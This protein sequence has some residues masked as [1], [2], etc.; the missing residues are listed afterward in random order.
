MN[1]IK[2]A[3]KTADLCYIALG[4]VLITICSWITVP[5]AVPF[6]MQTFAVF[7]VLIILG[8]K[9]GILSIIVY[10]AMGLIGIP[11]FS[12][13]KAGVGVIFGLTGGYIVGFIFI[14]LIYW[15]AVSLF[16]EKI[17]VELLS[18]LIGLIVCYAFGTAW[19]MIAYARA[20]ESVGILS[21]ISMCVFPF[22]IPDLI[23]LALSLIIGRKLRTL[24]KF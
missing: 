11:V 23:K 22:V 17:A 24:I 4:A 12:G 7:C 1:K 9:R 15:L 3:F 13:F 8:A 10:I 16:R 5:I 14:A 2:K 21:A 6:T 19:F 20:N 18:L